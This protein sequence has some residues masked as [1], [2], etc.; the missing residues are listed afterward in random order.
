LNR[1]LEGFQGSSERFGE[2]KNFLLVSEI[3]P[4]LSVCPGQLYRLLYS[5]CG[6]EKG[7]K[8]MQQA[9]LLY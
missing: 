8:I 5:G 2:K 9:T 1:I 3:D 4:Q 7:K 6:M